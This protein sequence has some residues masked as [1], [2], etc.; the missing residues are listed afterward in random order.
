MA[1]DDEQ[2]DSDSQ[3]NAVFTCC[4]TKKCAITVCINCGGVFHKSCIQ[5]N[6]NIEII[7][8]TI[9]KCCKSNVS[10]DSLNAYQGKSDEASSKIEFERLKIENLMLKR[11]LEES[12][13]KYKLLEGNNKLLEEN[14]KLLEEKVELIRK[15]T[16]VNPKKVINKNVQEKTHKAESFNLETKKQVSTAQA[17]TE[18]SKEGNLNLSTNPRMPEK[19]NNHRQ[20]EAA[21]LSKMNEIINLSNDKKEE[22]DFKIVTYRKK[23]RRPAK[24]FYGENEDSEFAIS[25]KVWLY[26]YRIKRHI[27]AERI[28]GFITKQPK[29]RDA[30]ICIKEL[31]TQESQNKCFMFGIDWDLRGDIYNP[32][33]WPRSMA[34]KRFDFTKYNKYNKQSREDF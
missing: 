28:K 7:S 24:K 18:Q 26:L 23:S 29:F 17:N 19:G 34:F 4:K 8:E 31:P 16:E 3:K 15:E 2:F 30:D 10:L 25:R 6:K 22:E 33:S 11:L 21:Q 32:S 9:V 12:E 5:R 20:L 13:I 14:K 1:T 27:T